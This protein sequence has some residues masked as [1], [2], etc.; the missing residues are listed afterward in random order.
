[1][2]MGEISS[3]IALVVGALIGGGLAYLQARFQRVAPASPWWPKGASIAAAV[4]IGPA[5]GALIGGLLGFGIGIVEFAVDGNAHYS[6]LLG[7]IGGI[8][9]GIIGGFGVALWTV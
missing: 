9:G 4:L 3:L 7:S 6:R 5:V 2:G 1:M 8:I